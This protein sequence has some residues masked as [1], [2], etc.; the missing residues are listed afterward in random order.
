MTVPTFHE[1]SIADYIASATENLVDQNIR[2]RETYQK[3]LD[4]LQTIEAGR[5]TV[6]STAKELKDLKDTHRT[7]TKSLS[8]DIGHLTK[9]LHETRNTLDTINKGQAQTLEV[10]RKLIRK[11]IEELSNA[12]HTITNTLEAVNKN[13]AHRL[14]T[15]QTILL[16]DHEE[17]SEDLHNIGETLQ[18]IREDHEQLWKVTADTLRTLIEKQNGLAKRQSMLDNKISALGLYVES[19]LKGHRSVLI[20]SLALVNLLLLLLH[21]LGVI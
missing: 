19:N 15:M 14:E 13:Q 21:V 20:V 16:K 6:E 3:V 1:V 10:V 8:S 12:L 7:T 4:A 17:L 2:M 11:D 9:A 18:A 5:A